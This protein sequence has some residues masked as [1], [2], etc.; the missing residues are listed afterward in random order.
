MKIGD[1][2]E[3]ITRLDLVYEVGDKGTIEKKPCFPDSQFSD[4]IVRLDK[5]K[6]SKLFPLW[7]LKE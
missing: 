1:R 7:N 4:W 6:N 2:V 5:F 3:M